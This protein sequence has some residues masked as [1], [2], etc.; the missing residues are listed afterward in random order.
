MVQLGMTSQG[1]LQTYTHQAGPYRFTI[2]FTPPLV[3]EPAA[4]PEPVTYSMSLD[5]FADLVRGQVQPQR[6]G[7]HL[8]LTWRHASLA[9]VV[10]AVVV[11]EGRN[12]DDLV[13]RIDGRHALA[14]E[15]PVFELLQGLFGLALLP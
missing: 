1:G 14:V 3:W 8:R 5:Q 2:R 11:R 13:C 4:S 7:Q 10:A 15:V 12:E 9:L 6:E